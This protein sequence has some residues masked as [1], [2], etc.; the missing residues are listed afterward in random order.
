M[1]YYPCW[2]PISLATN[3]LHTHTYTHVYTRIFPR[4]EKVK[5]FCLQIARRTEKRNSKNETSKSQMGT[6]GTEDTC[7]TL[8]QVRLMYI[9]MYH[10]QA[11]THFP[12]FQLS[13]LSF[14][15]TPENFVCANISLEAKKEKFE[16]ESS[17]KS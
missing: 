14:T 2:N 6:K 15:L 3:V 4:K 12:H 10:P 8:K 11:N 5:N 17:R 9:H 1:K 7:R 13:P 16:E